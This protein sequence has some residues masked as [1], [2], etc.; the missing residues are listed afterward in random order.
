MALLGVALGKGELIMA[1]KTFKIGD[2][3]RFSG[4][5]G[6]DRKLV[7]VSMDGPDVFEATVASKPYGVCYALRW[8]DGQPVGLPFHDFQ[9]TKVE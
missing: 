9:L 8:D 5:A 7:S 4:T 1:C 6:T 2:R 3:V